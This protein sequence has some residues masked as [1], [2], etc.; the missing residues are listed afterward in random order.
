M[1]FAYMWQ[2]SLPKS[3]QCS[4]HPSLPSLPVSG[5][6]FQAYAVAWMSAQA[7]S[8]NSWATAH[9]ILLRAVPGADTC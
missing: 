2:E 9:A 1:N 7:V 6:G 3:A 4:V 5:N 8:P